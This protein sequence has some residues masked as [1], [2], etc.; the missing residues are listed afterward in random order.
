[1]NQLALFKS[2]RYWWH[3]L[4]LGIVALGFVFIKGWLGFASVLL[5]GGAWFIP[6]L[7]F[8]WKIRHVRKVFDNKA[9]LKTF[10]QSEAIK[11]A[12][13]FSL[14][15]LFLWAWNVDYLSFLGGYVFM[16]MVSFWQSWQV[17]V[18]ND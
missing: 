5:G 6:S 1:M 18:K 3:L 13:S 7:Y 14:I 8:F 2:S 16:I 10:F 11:L 15:A 17:G 4:L 12:L 9:V